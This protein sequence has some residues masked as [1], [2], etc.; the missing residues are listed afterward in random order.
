MKD[1]EKKPILDR[2]AVR[3]TF[4]FQDDDVSRIDEL[5]HR[6]GND[7]TFVNKSEVVRLGLLALEGLSDKRV[8]QLAEDLRRLRAGRRPSEKTTGR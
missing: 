1:K 4:S 6:F 8:T 5:R 2:N 3:V 7:I